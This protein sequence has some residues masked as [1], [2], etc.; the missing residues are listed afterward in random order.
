MADRAGHPGPDPLGAGPLLPDPVPTHRLQLGLQLEG[1]GMSNSS[2]AQC[3]HGT[4]EEKKSSPV[5][6]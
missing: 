5:V 3:H 4:Y 2:L 1:V 6:R